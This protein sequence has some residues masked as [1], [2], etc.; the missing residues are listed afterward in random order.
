MKRCPECRRDY[1]DETLNFCLDDGATLVEGP[2]SFEPPTSVLPIERSEAPTRHQVTTTGE[3]ALLTSQTAGDLGQGK[4]RVVWILGVFL[5]VF[6]VGL[7]V[8]G[9]GGYRFY[10]STQT[11]PPGPAPKNIT[12]QRVTGDGKARGAEISP[13]GKFLAYIRTEGGE[14]SIWLKQI[15]TN[16]NIEMVKAGDLDRFDGLVFSPDGNFL[17]FNAQSSGDEPAV[18]KVPTLGGTPT[19]VLAKAYQV[20]F[21]PDGRQ[22]SF[23]RY[24]LPA[25][26]GAIYI[27]NADGTNERKLAVRSGTKF[28]DGTPAWSPDGKWIAIVS[29]DDLLAPNPNQSLTLLSV[30]GG[31]E[32]DLGKRWAVI[33][34]LVW[35][36][37]GDSLIVVASDSPLVQPQLWEVLYPGAAVR[38]LTSNLNGHFSVSIT[39][40]GKSIVTGEIYSK[41]AV[42][43][44]PDLK[45]ENAKAVMPAS[46]DTW[47]LSWTPDGRIVYAS[48]QTGDAEVWI[49]DPDGANAKSLTNDRVFKTVPVVSPDGRYIVYSAASG[50]PQLV[51]IDINGSNPMVFD[52]S[53][54]SDNPDISADSKWILYSAW[55][56]GQQR[57]F[58]VPIEGG[59]PQQLTDYSATEPRYSRDG[60][61]FS[62]FVQNEKTNQFDKLAIVS[63]DGGPPLTLFNIPP[64]TNISRSAVW[65]PDD[66]GITL[67]VAPGELQNLWLQPVDGG[68]AKPMTNFGVPGVARREYSRDGKRIA[69]VRAE[70]IGNAIMIT[71]FR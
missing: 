58:R 53:L 48:D 9:Y 66:K 7:A 69:I 30:A 62:C 23:G 38:R 8:I 45:P 47:G 29:G 51:R 10:L 27:A 15:H 36:P 21:S 33:D 49:M 67:I 22:I 44:S 17:Y 59:E 14:R 65:T 52:K 20:Q 46:G 2:G 64:L 28:F 31:E 43:V 18:Y 5:A 68:E 56:D 39:S 54:G 50:N 42:F 63:A 61:R 11:P 60:T 40:D 35:H 19:K 3:T 6:V 41:S 25:N 24:D 37:S 34:D 13:D 70:G 32:R 1:T 4:R 16:S 71:D 26:E 57:I 12:T 55:L